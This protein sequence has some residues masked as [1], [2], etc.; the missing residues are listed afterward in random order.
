MSSKSKRYQ[1]QGRVLSF[2][3][4]HIMAIFNVTPDSFYDGGKYSDQY[5]LEN[6]LNRLL[7]EGADSI[8]IGGVSSRPGA[9]EVSLEQE[10]S[11]VELPLKLAVDLGAT[12]SIDTTRAEIAKRAIN[13]GAHIVND[14]SCGEQDKQMFEVVGQ[15][16]IIYIAMHMQGTPQ[17]MQ[18]N[19]QYNSVTLDV[20]N[21]FAQRLNVMKASNINQ[22]IIDP[23]FGFG[24]K[25]E[26]NY[27]L[28][29]HLSS[30]QVFE[31]PILVGVSR[32]S[33]IYSLDQSKPDQ[34]LPG[35]LGLA[36]LA[37]K[38]GARLL[39]V[40]DVKETVQIVNVFNQLEANV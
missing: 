22:V 2:D 36:L 35:S 17:T 25:I 16:G 28:F 1:A 12:V 34:A 33:M 29:N 24:K 23:G 30:F 18:L 11:R 26:Q 31:C 21:Y 27:Q 10:W 40:H 9:S 8:D 32:K 37:L 5:D 14:I 4:P 19:P 6:Q 38:S 3:G 13:L 15:S 39:R 7:E 20:L